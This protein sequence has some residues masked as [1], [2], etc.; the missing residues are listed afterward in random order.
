LQAAL[1]LSDAQADAI[2]DAYEAMSSALND[3]YNEQKA[4]ISSISRPREHEL[5]GDQVSPAFRGC[6]ALLGRR[7]S[8]ALAHSALTAFAFY[9]TKIRCDK[10]LVTACMACAGINQRASNCVCVFTPRYLALAA[11]LHLGYDFESTA[12]CRIRPCQK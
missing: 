5:L 7:V 1:Q 2:C 12:A 6:I 10:Q 4:M 3:V 8:S 9:A 11:W